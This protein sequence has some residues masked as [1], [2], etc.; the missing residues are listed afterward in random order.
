[1]SRNVRNVTGRVLDSQ[2]CKVSSYGSED[3]FESAVVQVICVFFFIYLFIYFFFFFF[4]FFFCGGGGGG[5]RV[6]AH[7]S[8]GTFSHVAAHIPTVDTHYLDLAFVE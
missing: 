7:M 2:G 5:G 4:F 8:K 6:L 3:C 1:M